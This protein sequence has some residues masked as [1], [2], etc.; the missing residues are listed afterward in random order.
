M[1]TVYIGST[2]IKARAVIL[3]MGAEPKKLG[4]PGEEEPRG[5]ASST[6][7]PVTRPS[8]AARTRSLSAAATPPWRTRPS[9]P[10]PGR[11]RSPAA[12]VPC[13]GDHARPRA[14][15]GQHRPG[16]PVRR[17]SFDA[18][19]DGALKQVT[20]ENTQDGSERELPV[21]GAFVAIGHRP[22]CTS[23]RARSVSTTRLCPRRRPLDADEAARRVRRRR[24][25][26]PRLPPGG[27]GR[28]HGL[29]G[30]ARRRGLPAG[31]A[32]RP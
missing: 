2:E 17:A 28:R 29:H 7:P 16:H 30:R 14:R 11:H 32:D 3:A 21:T 31:H 27:H 12:G 6:A 10:R 18:G 8:S 24:P 13:L 23:W 15:K 5:A 19:D 20:L 9:R 4:V 22:N 1:H 25:D 26:R